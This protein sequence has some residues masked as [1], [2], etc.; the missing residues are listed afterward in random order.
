MNDPQKDTFAPA[1]GSRRQRGS[2][3]LPGG[4]QLAVPAEVAVW[5]RL[6]DKTQVARRKLQFEIGTLE[7]RERYLE[8]KEGVF[9][10]R[11]YTVLT[12]TGG[13]TQYPS[14]G[15][16]INDRGQDARAPLES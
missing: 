11:I 2:M 5:Q 9:K 6:L 1:T 4:A 12:A 3:S 8:L 13:N 7:R 10:R 16:C 14:S 15:S